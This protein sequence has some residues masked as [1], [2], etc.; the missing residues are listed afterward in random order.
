MKSASEFFKLST[1]K[2]KKN[3]DKVNKLSSED[4]RKFICVGCTSTGYFSAEKTCDPVLSKEAMEAAR[5]IDKP[6]VQTQYRPCTARSVK[7]KK[8]LKWTKDEDYHRYYDGHGNAILEYY[9][10]GVCD[11]IWTCD[12]LKEAKRMAELINQIEC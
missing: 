5:D 6:Y 9:P 10:S 7:G 2:Q 12:N 8:K 4:M 1:M 11:L 3:L